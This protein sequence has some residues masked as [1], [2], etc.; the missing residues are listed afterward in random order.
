MRQLS[1]SWAWSPADPSTDDPYFKEFAAQGQNLFQAAGD[2]SAWASNSEVF[3]ADDVYVTS[4]GGTDLQTNSAG[5]PWSSE[6]AWVRGGGGISP[7]QFPIPSWQ[8]PVIKYCTYCSQTYRNGPD[9]SANANWS[10]YVCADQTT[11]TANWVGGTSFAAPVWA[12]YLALANQQSV[13]FTGGTVGFINPTIYGI[14]LGPGGPYEADFH[15][16]LS[17]SNGY[18]AEIAYDLATGWGSPSGSG[19]IN[20]LAPGFSIA[21]EPNLPPPGFDTHVTVD[22]KSFGKFNGTVALTC[23]FPGGGSC[24][25]NPTSITGSGASQVTFSENGIVVTGTSGSVV[26]SV[27]LLYTPPGPP[28]KCPP[29]KRCEP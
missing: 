19:I 5:G 25:V 15:D 14:G 22:V 18:P 10:F 7:N 8:T 20:A 29:G 17:G 16:V 3:P 4:V 13:A 24:S 23:S 1:S 28:H 12:G 6:S 11:C 21:A 27:T 9:V 2:S 26:H